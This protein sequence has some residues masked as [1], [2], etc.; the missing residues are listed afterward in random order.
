ML[1]GFASVVA[2]NNQIMILNKQI[3]HLVE[4]LDSPSRAMLALNVVTTGNL[5][6]FPPGG[7][8]ITVVPVVSAFNQITRHKFSGLR[9]FRKPQSTL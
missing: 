8:Y 6:A 1:E 4:T 7:L 5:A 2:A 9:I 3:S